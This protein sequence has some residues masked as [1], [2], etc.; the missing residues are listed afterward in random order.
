MSKKRVNEWTFVRKPVI[1]DVPGSSAGSFGTL[2]QILPAPG[3]LYSE[4]TAVGDIHPYE[5]RKYS[6]ADSRGKALAEEDWMA[7]RIRYAAFLMHECVQ[8]D[9]DVR[10]GIPVLRGT[11]F[12]VAQLLQEL[13]D[14]QCIPDI[15]RRFRIEQEQM[16]RVLEGM[17]I[18]LDHS[19]FA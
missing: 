19:P 3:G 16:R 1:K 11:H 18:Y 6:I 2:L 5:W 10:S 15:A 4:V 9:P 13:A 7:E 12:T 17:A 14:G 8:V